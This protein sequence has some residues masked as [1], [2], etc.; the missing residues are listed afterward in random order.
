MYVYLCVRL[1]GLRQSLAT[2]GMLIGSTIASL[3]FAAT[4]S[5][6]VLT[7]TVAAVPPVLAL[8]WLVAVS[9]REDC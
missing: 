2:A 3:T 7:F 8:M 5:S 4:G 6:Y 9:P 1:T